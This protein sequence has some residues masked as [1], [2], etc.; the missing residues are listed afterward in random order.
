[1][2][3]TEILQELPKLKPEDLQEVFDRIC[4]LEDDRLLK[5]EEPSRDEKALLNQELED[6]QREP[7]TDS[8]WQEVNA[9]LR[10]QSKQ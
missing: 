3:K 9:R 8:S 1:M 10:R 5:G 6:F 2:S 4:E 7:A